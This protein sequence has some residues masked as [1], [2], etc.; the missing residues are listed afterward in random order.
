MSESEKKHDIE[1][2]KKVIDFSA[3]ISQGLE[4]ALADG[5]IGFADAPLLTAP[6]VALF[7]LLPVISSVVSEFKDLD[8][9]EKKDLIAYAEAHFD[10]ANDQAE[11]LAERS[12]AIALALGDLLEDALSRDHG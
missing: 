12:F 5:K 10:L 2:L 4:K 8:E 9:E 11:R 3:A 7:A 1:A 6:G